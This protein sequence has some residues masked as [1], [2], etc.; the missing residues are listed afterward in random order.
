MKKYNTKY[1]KERRFDIKSLIIAVMGVVIIVLLP[2]SRYTGRVYCVHM[3]MK[4]LDQ[5]QINAR[6]R[7]STAFFLYRP[8]IVFWIAIIRLQ[9][10]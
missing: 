9:K 3:P 6:L 2:V 1:L 4:L 8:C 10:R 5:L 7:P